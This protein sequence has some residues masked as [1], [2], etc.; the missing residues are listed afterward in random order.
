MSRAAV[1]ASGSSR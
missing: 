1:T